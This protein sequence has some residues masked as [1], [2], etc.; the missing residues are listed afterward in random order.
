M[1]ELVS[2]MI[3]WLVSLT[4]SLEHLLSN[5][6]KYALVQ[7]SYKNFA[8]S[9]SLPQ[10][11]S[12]LKMFLLE[13]VD[14]LQW[15]VSLVMDVAKLTQRN[16]CKTRTL[17]LLWDRWGHCAQHL[18]SSLL[19]YLHFSKQ[20][21]S[22]QIAAGDSNHF[23]CCLPV[24]PR[25][26]FPTLSLQQCVTRQNPPVQQRRRSRLRLK[27]VCWTEDDGSTMYFRKNPSR[28]STNTCLPSSLICVTGES[29]IPVAGWTTVIVT[30]QINDVSLY[31][32]VCQGIRGYRSAATEGDLRQ[33]RCGLW[34]A[35]TIINFM[36]EDLLLWPDCN[37]K[38][39]ENERQLTE[40]ESAQPSSRMTYRLG[41]T[42]LPRLLARPSPT[43][44]LQDQIWC[45]IV[46]CN[47]PEHHWHVPGRTFLC[48]ISNSWFNLQA[49]IDISCM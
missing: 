29:C 42:W 49:V 43:L 3:S 25:L 37:M 16:A 2:Y 12:C 15:K 24:K 8:Q 35:T 11:K 48:F 47:P 9:T 31:L 20:Y 46:V 39:R 23:F 5:V 13:A 28:A 26:P 34:T 36:N 7:S 17:T 33:A 38:E 40:P 30:L 44:Q 21:G 27:W 22:K 10:I 4:E 6:I 14:P 45:L 32:S 41:V 1:F 19:S 18:H